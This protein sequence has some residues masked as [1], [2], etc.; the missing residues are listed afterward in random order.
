MKVSK[1]VLES[2]RRNNKIIG[3]LMGAFD[4]HFRTIENWIENNDIRLT[5][6]LATKIIIDE[7]GISEDEI[8][9]KEL[10]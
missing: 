7:T 10:A 9:E 6:P 8:F 5:T 1:K 2:I 3:L 4:V